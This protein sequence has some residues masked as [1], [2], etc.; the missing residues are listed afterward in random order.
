[1]PLA[2]R[3]FVLG[4]VSSCNQAI[5]FRTAPPINH[6]RTDGDRYRHGKRQEGRFRAVAS[7]HH[8]QLFLGRTGLSIYPSSALG[9]GGIG[10]QFG[11]FT[12]R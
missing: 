10:H 9:N 6:S 7:I 2:E 12:S 3:L 11:S 8:E 4:L 1:M 5:S